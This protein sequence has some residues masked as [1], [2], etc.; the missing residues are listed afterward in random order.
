MRIAIVFTDEEESTGMP[1]AFKVAVEG[2]IP[3][4]KDFEEYETKL[5]P[6]Q[7]WGYKFYRELI[8]NLEMRRKNSQNAE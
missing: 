4:Q 3:E 1:G 5:S 8:M 2:D 7:N 6:A